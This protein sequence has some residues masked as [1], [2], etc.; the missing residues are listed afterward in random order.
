MTQEVV[1]HIGRLDV[2][3]R[4]GALDDLLRSGIRFAEKLALV[5]VREG[6]KVERG[7]QKETISVTLRK[8]DREY[9]LVLPAALACALGIEKGDTMEWRQKR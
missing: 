8:G 7:R 1:G 6:D 4:S 2:L 9:E 5:D 3:R